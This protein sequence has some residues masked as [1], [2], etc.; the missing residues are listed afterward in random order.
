ME[1]IVEELN[2]LSTDDA[3]DVIK[4]AET[5]LKGDQ[6]DIRKLCKPWGVVGKWQNR[7]R[8]M[9]T[10]KEELKMALTKRAMELKSAT[11]ASVG[12]AATDQAETA[13]R[14]DVALAGSTASMASSSTAGSMLQLSQLPPS[15]GPPADPNINNY[16]N[17]FVSPDPDLSDALAW[18][19]ENAMEPCVAAWRSKC[20]EWDSAVATKEH[21]LQK[22]RRKLCKEHG[23]PCTRA[24]DAGKELETTMEYIRQQLTNQIQEIRQQPLLQSDA[25]GQPGAQLLQS[26]VS[27]SAAGSML[28]PSQHPRS[29]GTPADPNINNFPNLFESPDSDL[30]TALAWAHGN[31]MQPRVAAWLRACGQWDSAVAT[32]EHMDQ[33]KR[34]KLCKEHDI[35]CTKLVDTNKE[36]VK[37]THLKRG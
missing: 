26:T 29:T 34:R 9:A 3:R 13:V 7:R 37:A 5:I 28:E 16:P 6:A 11:E 35:P 15:I 17:L 8:D 31:A 33:K 27:S 30:S 32:K 14:A 12:G 22:K 23:I 25:T 24:V 2:T 19:H 18:A 21:E 4:A 10:I 36:L 20:G 1:A